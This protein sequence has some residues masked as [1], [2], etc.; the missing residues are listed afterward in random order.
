MLRRLFI[1]VALIAA[2]ASLG[3]F[4]R[5]PH[6]VEASPVNQSAGS[7]S[8]ADHEDG[9]GNTVEF[10]RGEGAVWAFVEYPGGGNGSNL[11]YIMRLNGDDYKWGDLKCG[12]NC[13]SFA[14]RLSSKD[15]GGIPAVLTRCWS[16]TAT[17]RSR[18]VASASR[19]AKARTTTTTT[20]R[21]GRLPAQRL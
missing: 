13:S 1:G 3:S 9:S 19:A 16:T 5:Q 6:A 11:S 15:N 12:S 4:A 8:F 17:T 18:A 20:D 10:R 14:F 2:F 7:I 21:A